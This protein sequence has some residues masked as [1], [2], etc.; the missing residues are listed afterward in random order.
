MMTNSKSE[1][2]WQERIS[3][4]RAK[5]LIEQEM[6]FF[7]YI[8]FK[9]NIVEESE[10][11]NPTMCVDGTN[12]Y[13]NPKF[14][15]SLNDAELRF[16][17]AHEAMHVALNHIPRL[18]SRDHKI[19]NVAADYVINH[20]LT[21]SGGKALKMPKH[22]LLN[23]AYANM[24]TEEVYELLKKQQ[25]EQQNGQ[26]QNG[27]Y[28]ASSSSGTGGA[29][30][31]GSGDDTTS[32]ADPGG[33]GGLRMPKGSASEVDRQL[34]EMQI[35][36]SQAA[37][38]AKA[39]NAGRLPASVER[40]LKQAAPLIDWRPIVRQFIDDACQQNFSWQKQSRHS[41][42]LGNGI[43]LPGTINDGT[44]HI[45]VVI[46]TSGS[47]DED[48]LSQF[49]SEVQGCADAAAIQKITVVY[50]DATVHKED[51]FLLGDQIVAAPKGGGGTDFRDSFKHIRNNHADAPLI[52]YFTDMQTSHFGEE[53]DAPTKVLW[54]V[55][56]TNASFNN[57]APRA[58]FGTAVHIHS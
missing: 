31:D 6:V 33:T 25:Q 8:M 22:G 46:D 4:Q 34:A 12:L 5:M 29:D 38:V 58:P 54:A 15:A 48:I 7:G 32:G 51:T 56:G 16:V 35:T 45:V 18:R 55:Y 49:V 1:T 19:W 40:I 9:M 47:I 10:P 17:L 21:I 50:A 44:S 3:L 53:P 30:S 26:G 36:T 52:I 57:Y 23:G 13:V 2:S 37:A 28:S 20:E 14:V 41:L 24:P 42:A 11:R 27:S 39:K 43:Y